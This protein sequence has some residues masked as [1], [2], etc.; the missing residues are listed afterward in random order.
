MKRSILASL[1]IVGAVAVALFVFRRNPRVPGLTERPDLVLVT[2]DTLRAD[3]V[4]RGLT[5]AIDRLAASGRR[6]VTAR[7]TVPLTL[8]SH[9]SLMTGL[10]PPEHGVR[11]N[12]VVFR[13]GSPTLARVL[14]DAGYHTAAFVGAYVLDRRFGLADGFSTYDDRV[15]RDPDSAARLEA[16]RPAAAVVDAAAAWLAGASS[17]LFLWVHLYDPHAPYEPPP[18]FR[19]RASHPYDG[20]VLYADAEVARLLDALERRG[21]GR[22]P[23]VAIAG[24]HGEALGEHGEQTHGLLAYDSTL[25]VPL[26]LAGPGVEAG[27]VRQ[28][29]SLAD[30]GPS[31]WRLAGVGPE[32]PPGTVDLFAQP[33]AE[34]DV[35]AE[36]VYARVAGWHPLSVLAGE[37]W[38][39][40]ASSEVEL[41]DVAGDPGE[42]RNVAGSH[43]TVVEGMQ[44]A[45]S[46]L[47]SRAPAGG[48]ESP[49][50]SEAAERL[51]A[52]GY[53]S[54]SAPAGPASPS[55]PNPARTIDAWTTFERALAR[56]NGG[57]AREALPLLRELVQQHPEGLVFR[58]TLARALQESGDP[59]AAV[60][61]YKAAVAKWPADATLFHDLAVAARAAG[62]RDEAMRAEQ[63]A[64]AL[65]ADS[66]AALNG[67][68]LLHADAGRSREAAAAFE[69]AAAGDPSN[70]SYWTNLGNA[71]RELG[72]L[73]GAESAY[74]RALEADASHADA[75][76]GLGVLLV[77]QNRPA[78]AVEWFQRALARSP[79]F[80][81]ARLNLGIAWQES[82]NREKAV[83]AYRQVLARAPA[84]FTR[85][86][87]A[88]EALLRG[89]R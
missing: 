19:A 23:I 4:G 59:A 57:S 74:R 88:A 1:V 43:P 50:S 66:P 20:E 34:R 46:R 8:P 49:V 35:Y 27:E 28:P 29:V 70:A 55:A 51:R 72:D 85:E 60:A 58:T 81:E 47:A 12:G 26:V 10:L 53:V 61:I 84:R 78:E 21:G 15:P 40:I 25:R 73:A 75:A 2:I 86:R 48:T 33:G 36:S 7:A 22:R 64:L 17:P 52:L 24:D 87:E 63:A 76:N 80:H 42:T 62:D 83:E 54:G 9:V 30:L 82:G 3:R 69:R 77:Q 11:D 31:L 89:L 45:L 39:L 67:L 32:L 37:R 65:E 56:V 13:A 5:P 18:A 41:Y 79:D 14:R 71:R 44:A 38:K 68:G 6:F 16:E